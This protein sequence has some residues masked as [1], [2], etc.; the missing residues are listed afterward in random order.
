MKT[1]IDI[2]GAAAG[3]DK[4]R[5]VRCRRMEFIALE[6]MPGLCLD[7]RALIDDD[8][9]RLDAVAAQA[10]ASPE[11]AAFVERLQAAAKE[12]NV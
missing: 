8:I 4:R 12:G 6:V 3:W 1:A 5:I 9:E 11:H 10:I 7:P 2:K